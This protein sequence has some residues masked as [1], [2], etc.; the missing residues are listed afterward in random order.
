LPI[1]ERAEEFP[2]IPI[3]V[4]NKSVITPKP[5]IFKAQVTDDKGKPLISTPAATTTI[6]LPKEE[7]ELVALAKGKPENAIVW[8]AAFWLRMFKKAIHFGWRIL[9]GGEKS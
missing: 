3:E 8:F 5:T 2:E 1:E 6:T 9:R 7:A 4:E